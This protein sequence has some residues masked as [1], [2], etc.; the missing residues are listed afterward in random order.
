MRVRTYKCKVK[1]IKYKEVIVHTENKDEAK[2]KA[3]RLC[4]GGWGNTV[5]SQTEILDV[6][7]TSK[8]K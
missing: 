7:H 5:A 8:E 4:E 1:I 3:R 2:R 6:V